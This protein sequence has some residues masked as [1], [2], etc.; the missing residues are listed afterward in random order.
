VGYLSNWYVRRSRRRFWKSESD[1]DKLSAYNTLYECLVK[2]AKLLAPFIPFLAETIYQNLVVSVDN[3]APDSVHLTDYPI[4]DDS[5]IDQELSVVMR[6]AM[7][8]SSIGRSARSQA[9]IKVRQPLGKAMVTGLTSEEQKGLSEIVD[10][11]LEELNIK[12]IEF[13]NVGQELPES[14]V[15]VTEG[16]LTVA[17]EPTLTPELADEGLVREITHRLQ[18]LRRKAGFEIADNIVTYFESDEHVERVMNEWADYIKR[19]TLSREILNGLPDN[20]NVT[21]DIYKLEGYQVKL[22][23]KR[24]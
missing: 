8:V 11:V 12:S 24:V 18:G 13:L 20:D 1:A 17:V 14:A 3:Q 5:R 16:L 19:E 7:K 23:V 10:A 6:L 15:S 9:G 21:A 2:T 22:G 4:A